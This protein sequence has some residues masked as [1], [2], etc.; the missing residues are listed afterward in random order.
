[1]FA[2]VYTEPNPVTEAQ[3]AWLADYEAG[4]EDEEA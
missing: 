4:F 2:H 3:A 1:M